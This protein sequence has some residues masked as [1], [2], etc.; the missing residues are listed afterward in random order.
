[1]YGTNSH[2]CLLQLCI[3]VSLLAL[4]TFE[5]SQSLQSDQV[6][7]VEN[8]DFHPENNKHAHMESLS[9]NPFGNND[10]DSEDDG[11]DSHEFNDQPSEDIH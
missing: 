9:N 1:M 4:L 2:R 11:M 8:D 10:S 7:S 6:Y 5:E 3:I